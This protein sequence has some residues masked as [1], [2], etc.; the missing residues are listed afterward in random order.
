MDILKKMLGIV[1]FVMGPLSLYY[2]IKTG[3]VEMAKKPVIETQVQWIVFIVVS[4]PISVG[5]M[6]FG[7]FALRGEYNGRNTTA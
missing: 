1:W 7:W 6:I 5:L 3:S 4:V 2:L